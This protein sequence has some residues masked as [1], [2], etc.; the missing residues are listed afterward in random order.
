MAG[1]NAIARGAV[2]LTANADGMTS[3]LNK[4]EKK[5]QDFGK[6]A[7]SGTSN[8]G[9]GG[10]LG[11]LASGLGSKIL[12]PIAAATTGVVG[13]HKAAEKV[14][15]IAKIKTTAG[16]FGI[17]PGEFSAMAGVA[18]SAGSDIRDFTESLITMSTLGQ[19]AAKGTEEAAAAFAKL[20]LNADSFN[21]LGMDEKYYAAQDALSKVANAADRAALAGKLW[22]EDGMKNQIPLIGKSAAE[23]RAMGEA[24]K[25][26]TAEIDRAAAANGALQKAGQFLNSAWTK[27][28]VF[29]SPAI[30]KVVT[31]GTKVMTFLKPAFEW[32]GSYIET[33]LSIAVWV[34]EAIGDAIS[35]VIDWVKEMT[36]GMGDFGIQIPT[37]KEV[38]VGEF[39]MMGLAAAYVWD[40][41]KAGAGGVAV[42]LGYLVEK[43][44]DVA[45]N[46]KEMRKSIMLGAAD[47]ADA[48]GMNETAQGLR[49][50]VDQ[51]E[52]VYEGI[53]KAGE[54]MQA[55]GK[56]TFDNFG[57]SADQFSAWLDKK[58]KKTED[59]QKKIAAGMGA[60]LETPTGPPT[61]KWAA[62]V[63]K[64]SA[65][66]YSLNLK[67]MYGDNG[68]GDDP[69]TKQLKRN[70]QLQAEGNKMLGGIEKQL[71]DIGKF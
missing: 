38:V 41:L 12:G 11:G 17:D 33:K 69:Q 42:I 26:S 16:V 70:A 32:V 36:A 4:A 22:G 67:N 62:A 59:A 53:R 54:E 3:G 10:M 56:G 48:L 30:E 13:L 47:A 57:K 49:D 7:N 18:Q 50:S 51:V 60:G 6:R 39:K 64:G 25:L 15:E 35:E 52:A 21:K 55:W 9:S 68:Q 19:N 28:V 34:F 2:I 29:L 31:L 1:S 58:L 37:I 23:L 45:E 61:D 71:A 5:I 20:G 24:Y 27:T 43:F 44:S 66:A 63:E 8:G 65:A 14:A 40:G 46:F